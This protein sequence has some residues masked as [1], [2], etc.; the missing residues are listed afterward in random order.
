MASALRRIVPNTCTFITMKKWRTA[1][2]V[3]TIL[4]C[5]ATA[6]ICIYIMWNRLGLNDNMDFGAGAYYYADIPS[7]E[8]YEKEANFV[9]KVPVWAH[10]LLFLGWGYLMWRLWKWVDKR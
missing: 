1:A 6:V 3:A 8:Q 7:F 10:I 4:L 2:K 5:V 9:T